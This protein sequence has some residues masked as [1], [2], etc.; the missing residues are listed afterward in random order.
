MG[1]VLKR[2]KKKMNEM[3]GPEISLVDLIET[4]RNA[5]GSNLVH[6]YKNYFVFNLIEY[7]QWNLFRFADQSN[8]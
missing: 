6:V 5:L 2:D 7:F 1:Y 3:K 4:E 8:T